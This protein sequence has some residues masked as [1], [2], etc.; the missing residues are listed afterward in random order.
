MAKSCF[1]SSQFQKVP[2]LAVKCKFALRCQ[3]AVKFYHFDCWISVLP[4]E[5][6]KKFLSYY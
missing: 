4:D 6:K 2:P 3:P 1:F 5:Q